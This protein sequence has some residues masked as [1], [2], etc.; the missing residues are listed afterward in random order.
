MVD[1]DI[2]VYQTAEAPSLIF[3]ILDDN[4]VPID[5]SAATLSL[6]VYDRTNTTL[7]T[8][9]TGGSGITI[10][11]SSNNLATVTYTAANTATAGAYKYALWRT[12]G[13]DT[14]LAAGDFIIK[15]VVK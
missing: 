4:D 12:D 1:T 6:K 14:V 5:L 10:S 3:T 7:F 2:E 11:G 13:D 9:T 15:P 8:R